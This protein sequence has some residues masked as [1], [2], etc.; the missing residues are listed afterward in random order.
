MWSLFL[1][2]C[3][4]CGAAP[5]TPPPDPAPA[6][7]KVVS[8][9]K[10]APPLR[11]PKVKFALPERQEPTPTPLRSDPIVMKEL[12][13]VRGVLRDVVQDHGREPDNPWAIGHAILALGPKL[14]LTN[15]KPAI[16]W[17]FS[18]YAEVVTLEQTELVTF[19]A[20]RGDILVEPHTDLVLKALTEVGVP[21]DRAITVQGKPFTVAD[22]YRHS[23]ARAWVRG[24]V[25]GF[26]NASY[27]DTPWALQGLSSW[28]APETVWLSRADRRMTMDSFSNAVLEQ[29]EGETAGLQRAKEEG[30]S[31]QKDTRRG[32]FRYICG[33][34]HLLQGVVH[35]VGRGFGPDDGA[36]RVCKQLDL[37]L[38]RVDL[39]LDAVDPSIASGERAMRVLLLEQRMKFLGHTLETV[40]KISATGV[41]PLT[42]AHQT[43]LERVAVELARTVKALEDLGVFAD[44]Q[45]VRTDPKLAEIRRGG[46]EQVYLDF[47]GDSAHAVRGID[48]ALGKGTVRY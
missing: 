9:R 11:A 15:G 22:L 38:W 16:D 45:A 44:L 10:P 17:L 40:Y 20:K 42:E 18:E 5:E 24:T 47:I 12:R 26:H 34:Q 36:Q 21:P 19:P 43:E 2:L 37:L 48:L 6:A 39:E 3:F 1:V 31:V 30:K 28:A 27:D 32:V 33:G 13:R 7:P 46:G 23:L 14:A 25:T 29:L 35:A 8:P 4:G 41:C